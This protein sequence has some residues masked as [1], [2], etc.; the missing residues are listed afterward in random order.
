MAQPF[1][2]LCGTSACRGK[3]SGAKDMTPAQLEGI[4][5]NGH[6]IAL[7]EEQQLR[8]S[9]GSAAHEDATTKALRD[10]VAQANRVVDAARLAL[11][12]YTASQSG[13]ANGMNGHPT[14]NGFSDKNVAGAVRRGPTSREMSG[15]MGGDTICV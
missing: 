7:R 10:A 12:T 3:I 4:W 15:E 2:C 6:I 9:N 11:N 13:G 14:K 1:D 8:Q 5:L